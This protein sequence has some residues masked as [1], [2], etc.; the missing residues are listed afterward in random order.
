MDDRLA[1]LEAQVDWLAGQLDALD[2]RLQS[3]ESAAAATP[4]AGATAG[5]PE[6]QQGPLA[7]PGLT[8]FAGVVS[9]VGRT[10]VVLAGAYLLRALTDSGTLDARLGVGLGMAYALSWLVMADRAGGR[11]RTTSAAFHGIAFVLIALP[12]LFEATA[13]FGYLPP[14]WSA[15]GLA[16]FGAASLAVAARQ[17]LRTFAW[18]TTIGALVTAVGLM[19]L[20]AELGPFAIVLVLLG[21]GTLWCGYMFD[22]L[23]LRWPVAIVADFTV[24]VLSLRSISTGVADTPG[25]ALVVLVLLLATYLG[26]FAARTLFLNRNV[27]PFEVVQSVAAIF[28]GLG[29]AA[30]VT[31]ATGVGTIPV[32]LATILLGIGGYAV[33]ITFVERRQGRRRNFYFYTSAALVFTIGGTSLTLTPSTLTLVLAGLAL[34]GAVAGRRSGRTT[35]HSHAAVY[36][37]A[38][39]LVCGLLA[40][41]AHGLGLPVAPSAH[42]ATPLMLA[43]LAVCLVC[44]WLLGPAATWQ[45]AHAGARIPRLVVLVIALG[46]VMGTLADGLLPV[47]EGAPDR[48]GALATLRTAL[49]AAA[50]LGLAWAGSTASFVEGAWLV[51]PL[52]VAIGVKF[53]LEDL[54]TSRP[55]TLFLAF[56]LYGVALIVGPRLRRRGG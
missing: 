18:I 44:T 49:L 13:R 55:A 37:A 32:G 38:A 25:T 20:T 33:A 42:Q 52:L 9:L 36:A 16:V 21:V 12:L 3:L 26:S 27:I 11:R 28:V 7:G 35:F 24:A 30:Y 15:G 4:A 22:W 31:R 17:R 39:A 8:D 56:A 46:G 29:G 51:Y 19:F 48:L 47:E 2:R 10:L 34:V 41:A 5:V 50:V 43:V 40:H 6:V 45:P 1:R 14:R 23:L 54:R 53:V